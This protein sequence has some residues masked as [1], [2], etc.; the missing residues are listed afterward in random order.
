MTARIASAAE[1]MFER[2]DSKIAKGEAIDA[3]IEF[4]WFALDA[5][6][7]ALYHE[8]REN[9]A[10]NTRESLGTMLAEAE[11]RIWSIFSL[12]QKIILQKPRYK[13]ALNFLHGLVDDLVTARRLNKA[14]PDDLLSRLVKNYSS[15]PADEKMLQDQVLSFLLAGH[16]TSANGLSWTWFEI[17]KRP[18]I[19]EKIRAEV[20]AVLGDQSLSYEHLK[21]LEYTKQVFFEAMRLYPPVWTMSRKA[22]C[23]D[24]IPLDEGGFINVP[25]GTTI[26]LCA[27]AVHRRPIYWDHP[28]A[29]I[30]ERFSYDAERSRSKLAWFPFGSGPRLCLGL[31]FAEIESIALIAMIIQRYEVSLVPGQTIKAEPII[32]LRPNKAIYLKVERRDLS[33]GTEHDENPALKISQCPFRSAA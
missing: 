19:Q 33:S 2:W 20:D 28:E 6:L 5:L 11:G 23:D 8:D 1:S 10:K 4:M 18:D 16:E 31:K 26:M 15:D 14:Y 27:N 21:G 30:P 32:T 9:I 17:G 25:K 29:F 3:N 7:R 24:N 13:N 22:M 12:P